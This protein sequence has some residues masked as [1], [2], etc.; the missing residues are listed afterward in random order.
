MEEEKKNLGIVE[1]YE[2]LNEQF[3]I[4]YNLRWNIKKK[5]KKLKIIKYTDFPR[6]MSAYKFQVFITIDIGLFSLP[7]VLDDTINK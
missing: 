7:K 3:W 5:G 4:S 1:Y 2:T 6:L